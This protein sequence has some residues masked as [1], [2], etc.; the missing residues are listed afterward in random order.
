[1]NNKRVEDIV[2]LK[3]ITKKY[4]TDQI[5]L[6]NISLTI[7]TGEMIAILGVSGSGKTTLM[8]I[9]G[10]NIKEYLGSYFFQGEDFSLL[11]KKEIA[12]KKN[13]HIGYILQDFGLIEDMTVYNN[14]KLPLLFNQDIPMNQIE[15][16]V[17]ETLDKVNLPNYLDKKVRLLSGGEKQRVA[18]ARAIINNPELV[19]ADEPTGS[20]DSKNTLAIMELFEQLNKENGITFIITTHNQ[21]VAQICNKIIYLND[22]KIEEN[23][24]S[25]AHL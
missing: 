17:A 8:N 20:L 2:V 1:M 7:T 25:V 18:I 19:I 21:H 3:K 14:L 22:G 24:S 23:T 11:S 10:G 4:G 15:K 5:A 9:I 16:I 6:H 13:K 12:E